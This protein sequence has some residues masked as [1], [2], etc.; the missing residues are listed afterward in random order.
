VAFSPDGN[1]LATA[2]QDGT[3]RLWNPDTGDPV[4]RPL[5]G[6]TAPVESVAFSPDGNLLATA[7][8]DGTVRLWNP[9]TG[10]P[11]GRPLTGH[12]DAVAS[13]AFSPD[14]NLLATASI[15]G[16]VRL[17]DDLRDRD[18]ACAVATKY[19]SRTQ[20]ESYAPSGWA[21]ACRYTN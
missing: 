20:V 17:W 7:G 13:V 16:T 15:D 11:V 21:P 3:V 6:H 1:L 12:T 4:G 10:D 5:T 8:Q 2:G 18:D 19:V 14:G 9:D